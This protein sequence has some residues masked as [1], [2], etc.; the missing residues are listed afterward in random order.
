MKQNKFS[1]PV[2][3]RVVEAQ[4]PEKAPAKTPEPL[5]NKKAVKK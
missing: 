2:R 4:E 5:K 3:I 1:A